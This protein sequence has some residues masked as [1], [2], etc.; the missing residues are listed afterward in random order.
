[1]KE[2]SFLSA[3]VLAVVVVSS[4]VTSRAQDADPP[5]LD[6]LF[7]PDTARPNDLHVAV[8]AERFRAGST[9]WSVPVVIS[10]DAVDLAPIRTE[11]AAVEYR[12]EVLGALLD[13]AGQPIAKLT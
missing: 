12:L 13:S 11:S 2:R 3:A 4:C 8:R 9:G 5:L 6:L 10:V 7:A 1:M